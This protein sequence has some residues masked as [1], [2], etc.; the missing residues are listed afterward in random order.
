MTDFLS[1]SRCAI[2]IFESRNGLAAVGTLC[3]HA[4]LIFPE[5]TM[6][7]TASA[8][9]ENAIR[10]AVKMLKAGCGL[11][12]Q[13]EC[14]QITGCHAFHDLKTPFLRRIASKYSGFWATKKE[15]LLLT[16]NWRRNKPSSF[17]M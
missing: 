7:S 4:G 10:A 1:G 12:Q 11:H 15:G 2:L 5:G 6:K 17:T 8:L 9:R 3:K 14:L 16:P 13:F